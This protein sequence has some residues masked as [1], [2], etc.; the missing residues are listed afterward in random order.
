MDKKIFII[1]GEASGDM[2]GFSLAKALKKINPEIEIYGMGGE[3]M[4]QAGV[5]IIFDSPYL[6]VTGFTEVLKNLGKFRE[7]FRLLSEKLVQIKPDAVILI[8]YPGFNLR[9]AK[10]VKELNLKLIYYISP[11]IWAWWQSRVKIISRYVDKMLVV[12]KFEEDFYKKLNINVDF[13]GHPLIDN[14]ANYVP[15][16]G[17][18]FDEFSLNKEEEIIA[19]LPGSRENEVK[20]ILPVMLEATQIIKTKLKNV[21]FLICRS[22]TVKKEIYLRIA[23]KYNQENL[24]WLDDRTYDC[25]SLCDFTLVCSGTATLE[26]A[27]LLKPM[28]VIYKMSLLSYLIARSLIKVRH[29]GLVNIIAQKKLVS[30]F[31]QFSAQPK[32]IAGYTLQVLS[33]SYLRKEIEAGLL[34]VKKKLGPPGASQRAAEKIMQNL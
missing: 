20:N 7:A 32:K 19:L 22:S 1:A 25:I 8:D 33:D 18:L 12:F 9:F 10:K 6:A 34:E 3:K 13:V 24:V 31:I 16:K 17:K 14:L 21:K 5:E 23:R 4:R 26:V 27:I 30:E 2:H 29:I 11:Q 15:E 28:A